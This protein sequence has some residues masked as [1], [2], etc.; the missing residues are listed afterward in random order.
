MQ[1]EG[2]NCLHLREVEVF[3]QNDVNRALNM[4]AIQSSTLFGEVA[5]KAMNGDLNDNSHTWDESGKYHI[6]YILL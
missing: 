5:S 4:P 6:D 1:L 2:R 3:D